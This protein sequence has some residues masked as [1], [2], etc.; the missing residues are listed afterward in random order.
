[1]G[2]GRERERVMQASC[3]N[4]R[5]V[6]DYSGDRPVFCAY[7]GQRLTN[8][9]LDATGVYTPAHPDPTIALGGETTLASTTF[10]AVATASSAE[11]EAGSGL[12]RF[13]TNEEPDPE[14][15]AGY[16]IV[17]LLGRGGMGSVYEAEDAEFGRRVAL[18]VIAAAHIT[19]SEA[20]ER[21]RQEGRLASTIAHPRCVFVLAADE[22]RGRPYIVMELMPGE[23]LQTLVDQ[24]G[25]LPVDEAI[26]K[27]LDIIDGLREA[28]LQGVIHRDVKPS[29][30]FL[31]ASGR[32]K[33][34]DFGLSKSLDVDSQLTR[35]GAFIGTPLYASPEQIK[36]DEVD[37]RTDVY[38]V[39]ATLYFL[40][41]ARPPFEGGDATATLAKIVSESPTPLRVHRPEIPATLE[42]AVLR[43]LERDRDRRWLDLA[44]FRGALLPFVSNRMRL[45]D[46]ALR[47]SAFLVDVIILGLVFWGMIAILA[48]WPHEAGHVFQRFRRYLPVLFLIYRSIWIAYFA[49]LEG[50]WGASVGKRLTGLRVR[51]VIGGGPPGLKLALMRAA[52]F[53]GV[54][55]I[56]A[57][58]AT[59]VFVQQLHWDAIAYEPISLILYAVGLL[60][61]ASTMRASNGFQGIHEWISGTRVVRLDQAARR[62]APRGRRAPSRSRERV[63]AGPVGVLKAVGPFRVRGAVRWDGDRRVLLGEDSTLER[64]VWLVLR[65]KG[66]PAP[67]SARRDLGRPSRPRWLN[68]GEQSEGRW[69]A[70]AAPLGCPLAD[71]AGPEGLPWA[72][73]RPILHELADELAKAISEKTLPEALSVEQV[74]VQPDGSVQLVDPIEPSG[75]RIVGTDQERALGLL[76]S[77]AALALEGGRRRGSGPPSAIYA[78]VPEHA[79]RVLDRL[80]GRPRRGDSAYVDVVMLVA[81]LEADREKPT[82]VGMA[83]RAAH[84]APA[85]VALSPWLA[86]MFFVA[87]RPRTRFPTD[88]WDLLLFGPVLLI[89]WALLTRGGLLLRLAGIA[90]IRSDGRP[91]EGWRCA[92]RALVVW[93]PLV[94]LLGLACYVRVAAPT[95]TP[96]STLLSPS[97]SPPSTF[98]TSL[99]MVIGCLGIAY[100]AACLVLALVFPARSVHDRLAGTSLVPK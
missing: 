25:P 46:Q 75:G 85:C 44:R 77:T 87:S 49:V 16:K 94:A 15:I 6:L 29:N 21:F 90:L 79:A 32:V 73:A 54:A 80:I 93:A 5:R 58:V 23:T 12:I 11:T 86:G 22:E 10:A 47:V 43:G 27:V 7:C 38:S 71:L 30:C 55:F 37:A 65:P 81:D 51:R 36:R 66:S 68:G 20:V 18:K 70:Y 50:L 98:T 83:R 100:L 13:G 2:A 69:D 59:C 64:P 72:D 28:H 57:D 63:A 97:P 88:L 1:M 60:A 19:S 62:R 14:R 74:W 24:R 76:R 53:C 99:P 84:L 31:E 91:A 39:A 92:W 48:A 82:E 35:T 40:L 67:T 52:T 78:A 3:P 89:I 34:G 8:A 33:V 42:S 9:P 56:A 45:A 41:S 96:T 61:A 17:R 4:C 26:L 95:A